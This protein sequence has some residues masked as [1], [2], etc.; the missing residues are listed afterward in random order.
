MS[1]KNKLLN[2]LC[3]LPFGLKGGNSEI[4]GSKTNSENGTEISQEVSDERVGKHLLKGEVTQS[5]EELRYKTYKVANESENYKFIGDGN[6]V[7]KEKK[8][9]SKNKIKF[10]QENE[11]ICESVLQILNQVDNEDG[12]VEMYRLEFS[13]NSIPRFKLEKYA[14][15][16]DVDINTN[17][18]K[19]YTTLHFNLNANP[20]IITSKQFINE[21]LKIESIVGNNYAM[22]RN[23]I[24][25]SFETLSFSTYKA[26]N[27]DDFTNY[28]F[29]GNPT[30]ISFNKND[31]EA[32]LTFSWDS[33]VRLPLNLEAKYYSKTMDEKYINKERKDVNIPLVNV[34]RKRFC[35]V[36]GKEMSTYDGDIQEASGH[37]V[38]CSDCLKK[39][40]KE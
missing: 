1:L 21:I 29:M 30:L 35:S 23:D 24:V 11:N 8:K 4:F 2:I 9:R 15:S 27:E 38:I 3:S 33:F 32:M 31:Y 18:N 7:K 13:Y 39:A 25:S 6:A 34:E 36:C 17:E 37:D 12:G 19:I 5:V 14:T 26:T 40:L 10:T 20:Y 22:S 16:V 28:S